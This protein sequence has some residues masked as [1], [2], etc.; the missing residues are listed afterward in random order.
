MKRLLPI[1]LLAGC[2]A[3]APAPAPTGIR[4]SESTG[5]AVVYGSRGY[6]VFA[7]GPVIV[8]DPCRPWLT[9][10]VPPGAVAAW[11]ERPAW[12][13]EYDAIDVGALPI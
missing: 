5:P 1:V 7:R 13:I 8:E 9:V 12:E 6:A 11:A 4:A 2:A 3:P 10:E